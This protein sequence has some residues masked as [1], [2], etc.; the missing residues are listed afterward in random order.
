MPGVAARAHA[1]D[2]F[3]DAVDDARRRRGAAPPAQATLAALAC[4]V[5]RFGPTS[6]ETYLA[7]GAAGA[8]GAGYGAAAAGYGGAYSALAGGGGYGA[9]LR[10]R[11]PPR[12][13]AW[14][15]CLAEHLD[16][17]LWHAQVALRRGRVSL[18]RRERSLA[19]RT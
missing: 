6:R 19:P 4:F 14:C 12:P 11:L 8:Y 5:G 10:H 16:V 18:A 15:H 2:L 13:R 3:D 1:E 7:G 17:A 9:T